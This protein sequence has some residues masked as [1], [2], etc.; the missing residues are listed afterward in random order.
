MKNSKKLLLASLIV[1]SN[2]AFSQE[3]YNKDGLEVGVGGFLNLGVKSANYDLDKATNNYSSVTDYENS[4]A[5][6][7]E[8]AALFNVNF[9]KKLIILNL[10]DS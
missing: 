7:D 1:L 6:I 2:T 3:I 5:G 8:D 10:E 9:K 4:K